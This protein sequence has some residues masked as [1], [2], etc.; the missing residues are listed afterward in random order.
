MS[1]KQKT[2]F[3]GIVSEITAGMVMFPKTDG[4]GAWNDASRRAINIVNNYRDGRG[5]F[6]IGTERSAFTNPEPV[7]SPEPVTETTT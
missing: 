5:I 2:D 7:P 4:D 6:Q 3:E 1:E